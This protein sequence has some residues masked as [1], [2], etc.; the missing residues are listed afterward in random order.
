MALALAA[1]APSA[2]QPICDPAEAEVSPPAEQAPAAPVAARSRAGLGALLR[3]P[4]ARSSARRV[5]VPAW[6]LGTLAGRFVELSA[7]GSSAALAFTALLLHEAQ[8]QGE[9]VAWV[10]GG[11]SLFYPPDLAAVGLDLRA[12]PIIRA[13]GADALGRALGHLMRSGA[14]GLVVID[15]AGGESGAPDEASV[16]PAPLQSRLERTAS[17]HGTC[18]LCLTRKAPEAGSLGPLVS[19]RGEARRTRLGGRLGAELVALKDKRSTPGW[20]VTAALEPVPG[21]T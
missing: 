3:L 7:V 21:L 17:A 9:P 4:M 5:E 18:L 8:R 14:F 13:T 11:A 19:F 6:S 15:L 16:L 10:Q 2:T 20:R 12:L 1:L